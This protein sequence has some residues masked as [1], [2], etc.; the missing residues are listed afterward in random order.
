MVI[1]ADLGGGLVEQADGPADPVAMQ[2]RRDVRLRDRCLQQADGAGLLRE[3]D[4][5]S[6]GAA[7]DGVPAAVEEAAAYR[8]VGGTDRDARS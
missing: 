4:D 6:G 8:D 2:T 3:G 5:P 7:V 1:T